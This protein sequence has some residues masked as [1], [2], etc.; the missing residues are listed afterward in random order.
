MLI[1]FGT[2]AVFKCTTQ[3]VRP[4]SRRGGT[5]ESLQVTSLSIRL[6]QSSQ[7]LRVGIGSNMAPNAP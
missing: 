2:F 7:S 3:V 1:F 5:Q 4:P 6:E